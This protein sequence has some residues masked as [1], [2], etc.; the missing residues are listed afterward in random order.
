[1][2]FRKRF[3]GVRTRAGE[4]GG[5]IKNSAQDV[6][7]RMKAG[8]QERYERLKEQSFERKL[9]RERFKQERKLQGSQP[10]PI[11]QKLGRVKTKLA[12]GAGLMG[13]VAVG[14]AGKAKGHG[15]TFN[16]ILAFFLFLFDTVINYKGFYITSID[17]FFEL[18][19]LVLSFSYI[20]GVWALFYFFMSRDRSFRALVSWITVLIILIVSLGI[21]FKLNPMAIVHITFVLLLWFFF[22]RQRE[23]AA[24]ANWIL[25]ALLAI[26]LYIY[27][28]VNIF[29]P[30]IAESIAGI[31]ILFFLSLGYVYEQTNNKLALILIAGV[32]FW[33]FIMLGPTFA[34]KLDLA[35]IEGVELEIPSFTEL[36]KGSIE[37][38]RD[39][40]Q[41]LIGA[42]NEWMNMRTEY[43][44]Y[45]KVEEN[46]YE[47]LGVY[48]EDVE[49]AE[50][51][52]YEDENIIVWGTVK[53]KTLDDP[54]YITIG[55]YAEK[56]GEK[57]KERKDAWKVDPAE[58]FEVITYD[59][60]D[61][62]C[63][64]S[65]C[66]FKDGYLTEGPDT[67][68]TFADFNFETLAYLK[69][70]FIDDERRKAMRREDLDPLEEYGIEDKEPVAIYTNGPVGIGM[71]TTKS[72]IAVKGTY[73]VYPT[74]K[75]SL[76]NREGWEGEITK[77]KDLILFFPKGIEFDPASDC[78]KEFKPAP[79]ECG[80]LC[81]LF[82]TYSLKE[83]IEN[84]EKFKMFRCKF[85]PKKEI[86]GTAPITTGFFR[87][88]ALYD[89]T[90]EKSAIVNIEKV[91]D[92]SVKPPTGLTAS[93]RGE[94]AK[95]AWL[96][97]VDD[98]CKD[99]DSDELEAD[100]VEYVIY[101]KEGD[102]GYGRIGE[103]EA[104]GT[105]KYEYIDEDIEKGEDMDIVEE[106]VYTYQVEAVDDDRNK[107]GSNELIFKVV[108][109]KEPEESVVDTAGGIIEEAID[110]VVD[111]IT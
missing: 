29:S 66:A 46:Q 32:V 40:I 45:G 37:K 61:F 47:P 69:V 71:E 58:E 59:E 18:F 43:A 23:D 62:A 12:T 11:A 107:A 65:K 28:I 54:I 110:Y 21:A 98:G 36:I 8:A 75:I 41:A 68:T 3:E 25:V 80:E 79:G 6:G 2:A 16:V 81:D 27:S 94:D 20:V 7:G 38:V 83:D 70:Y 93:P 5:G 84:F 15:G 100:V 34:E 9:Q 48:L 74:L 17:S 78:N 51:E 64:F 89:Y 111:K 31:P 49:S 103:V 13:G 35:G 24:T 97:S 67:I 108:G 86:L 76:K 106:V 39:S 73:A 26:D 105:S 90:V 95:L 101:R 42:G 4:I 82:N 30:A 1:M 52:Y 33:Y 19:R 85:K 91:E 77:L 10:R 109:T 56:G 87:V 96:K 53:A 44:I 50:S 92:D 88:K 102:G 104:A 99:T 55:C 14:A 72:L 63:T 57:D 60:S 22:I